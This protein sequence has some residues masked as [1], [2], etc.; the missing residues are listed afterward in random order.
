MP[1]TG[2]VYHRDF[3]LHDTGGIH[4][5]SKE[6]LEAIID[7]LEETGLMTELVSIDPQPAT[8]DML[9][10]VHDQDYID[11][12][13]KKIENGETVLDAGDTRAGGGSWHA[14][15]LAAGGVC[16]AVD[17]VMRGDVVRAFCAVRPPGHHARRRA[18]M[19]FCIFNNVAVAVR[20]L[21][22]EYGSRKIAVIDWDVHHGNS[23]QEIFYDDPSVLYLS[24]HQYPHFPHTGSADETGIGEGRGHTCNIPVFPRTNDEEYLL[25]F[26]DAM[27]HEMERFQP[28]FIFISA[29]FDAHRNDPLG[30]LLLDEKTFG[31]LTRIIC[32]YADK[33]SSG[34]VV[35]VL[36]GGYALDAL[37]LSVE[38][39]V[40]ELMK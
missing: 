29:G 12:V 24:I 30:N 27:E 33:F 7:R 37:A 34:K 38:T 3:L 35:S 2:L 8:T 15:L 39:H 22:K 18:A 14:A 32:D 28:A 10:A 20:H 31:E 11:T 5:E 9:A 1:R 17:A 25:L 40:R 36:E 6:R 16:S 21:Q 23:T 4:P 26:E 13:R 19:G